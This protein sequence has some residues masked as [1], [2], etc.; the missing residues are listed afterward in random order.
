MGERADIQLEAWCV[1]RPHDPLLLY[2][3]HASLLNSTMLVSLGRSPRRGIFAFENGGGTGHMSS[4][5]HVNIGMCLRVFWRFPVVGPEPDSGVGL[6]VGIRAFPQL[7]KPAK[8][9]SQ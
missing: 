2:F 5:R 1:H 6:L 7:L 8:K 9:R 4:S 3:Y